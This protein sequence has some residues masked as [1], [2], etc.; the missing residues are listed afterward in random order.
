[1]S[2]DGTEYLSRCSEATTRGYAEMRRTR[3]QWLHTLFPATFFTRSDVPAITLLVSQRLKSSN[4][5]ELIGEVLQAKQRDD[6]D[7]GYSRATMAPNM[8]LNDDDAVGVFAYIDE[9]HFNRHN[10]TL[11]TDYVR[12][13]LERRTPALPR[14][15]LEGMVA[16]YNDVEFAQAP[17]TLRPLDWAS[18]TETAALRKDENAPR[19]LLPAGEFFGDTSLLEGSTPRDRVA[20]AQR[21]L[22]VRWALDPSNGVREAFWRFAARASE[23]PVTEEMF[24]ACFGF[25]FSDLRDRLSDYLPLAVKSSL[26]LSLALQPNLPAVKTRVATP[27]EIARLRGEWERL[28]VP[29]VRR[30]FPKHTARY[31]DQARRTLQRAYDAGDRDPRLVASLGLCELDAGNTA[32]AR[33]Y[34]AD[35]VARGVVRPRASFELARLRWNDLTHGE[36][37]APKLR[38][39]EIAPIVAPLRRGLAQT[40]V[41]PESVLLFADAWLACDTAPPDEDVRLL[42]QTARVLITD[43]RVCIRVARMLGKHGQREAATALLSAAFLLVHDDVTRQQFAQEYSALTKAL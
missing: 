11:S 40:P 23:E 28:S 35:A 1:V 36:T 32:A 5:A 15:L 43:S 16:V 20:R 24:A 41:L 30:R 37:P 39:E 29:L 8:M 38:A 3:M 21:A 22:L 7:G 42:E 9:A 2:V 19:V 6:G 18:T 25:G 4:N 14:W 26:Q 33:E 12:F 17:I 31:L 13:L 34:L 27:S 10:L